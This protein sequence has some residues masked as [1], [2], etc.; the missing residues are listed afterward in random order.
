MT[1]SFLFLEY[2]DVNR[3]QPC[4]SSSTFCCN[5]WIEFVARTRVNVAGGQGEL[6][7][8]ALHEFTILLFYTT[9]DD[10]NQLH[11]VAL[12]VKCDCHVMYKTV[13]HNQVKRMCFIF[14]QQL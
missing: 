11:I 12:P 10:K 6:Y 14:R 9:V 13:L 5:N 2:C 4:E 1:E 7:F 3:V 8:P